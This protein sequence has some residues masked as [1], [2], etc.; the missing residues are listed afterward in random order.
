MREARLWPP[1]PPLLSS[2]RSSSRSSPWHFWWPTS[3]A[4]GGEAVHRCDYPGAGVCPS[5]PGDGQRHERLI[6]R[7]NPEKSPLVCA[8]C[9]RENPPDGHP[10]SLARQADATYRSLRC[11]SRA[12]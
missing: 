1:P 4:D 7:D 3:R 10:A 6:K 2:W 9:G 5:A 11:N 12:F 8:E